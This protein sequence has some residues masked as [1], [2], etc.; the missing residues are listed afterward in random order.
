MAELVRKEPSHVNLEWVL[1]LL[2]HYIE[3][4]PGQVFIVD[5]VPN[6]K[7]LVRNEHLIKEC[8]S[9]MESFEQKV[10]F[11]KHIHCTYKLT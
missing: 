3:S 2:Q 5:I 4:D 9:E 11:C 10:E 1:R 6:L 7:W 8:S